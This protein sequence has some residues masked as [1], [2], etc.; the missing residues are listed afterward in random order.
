MSTLH[1]ERPVIERSRP[2]QSQERRHAS[3]ARTWARV[4]THVRLTATELLDAMVRPREKIHHDFSGELARAGRWFS[5]SN[6]P[7]TS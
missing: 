5:A 2:S 6:R 3:P 4:E 7:K 1:V